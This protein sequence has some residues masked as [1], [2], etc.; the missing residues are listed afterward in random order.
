MVICLSREEKLSKEAAFKY[1]ILGSFGSAIFL[2]GIAFIFGVAGTTY[3]N[4][5]SKVSADLI[6][7]N[8]LFMVGT[9]LALIGFFFK[10]GLVPFHAW[11]PD[12]YEGAPSPVTG[13][14]AAGVKVVTFAAILRFVGL[15]F[16]NSERADDLIHILQWVAVGSMLL[17]NIAAIMQDN[18]KRMLAYSSISHSGYALVGVLAAGLSGDSLLGSSGT[19]F[20]IFAYSI[21]T[22]GT[23]G[24]VSL[25]EHKEDTQVLI[26]DLKGLSSRSPWVALCMTI[27]LLS[28]AGIPPTVGFFGKLFIFSAAIEQ[29]LI[30]L[31]VWGV[32]SSV[33]S[34][35]YYLK[36]IV[37]MY[38]KK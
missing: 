36:P 12:V 38:M 16:L 21:M 37:F 27:M 23:F 2:Y 1:F 33:I 13:F 17:G 28:L 9:V 24:F 31:S 5:L 29:V 35:Y 11:S 10:V 14:M 30:W 3:L 25:F 20:Y 22:V 34:V 7:T 6:S 15:N 32:I 26:S 18:L 8:R 19:M 4:E